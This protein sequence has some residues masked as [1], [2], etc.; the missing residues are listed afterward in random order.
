MG[1]YGGVPFLPPLYI[2]R[3]ASFPHFLSILLRYCRKCP[4][5]CMYIPQKCRELY[6]LVHKYHSQYTKHI[7][8]VKS[9]YCDL[10]LAKPQKRKLYIQYNAALSITYTFHNL[11]YANWYISCI[12]QLRNNSS[13]IYNLMQHC[14]VYTSVQC[15]N[16]VS[17]IAS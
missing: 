16:A 6:I 1:G 12:T 2:H 14:D 5:S 17:R 3:N 15:N 4:N 10:A 7:N 8:L 13:C 11:C 9:I